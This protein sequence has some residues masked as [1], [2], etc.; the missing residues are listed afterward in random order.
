MQSELLSHPSHKNTLVE[1]A[2]MIDLEDSQY[3]L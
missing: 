1:E 2:G 3:N